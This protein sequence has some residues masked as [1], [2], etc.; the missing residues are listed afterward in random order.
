MDY[1]P[2]KAKIYSNIVPF[3]IAL[4]V[5]YSSK[6]NI[7]V[8][9]ILCDKVLINLFFKFYILRYLRFFEVYISSV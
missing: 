5:S 2:A 4:T 9:G 7:S 3:D 8:M 1:H 6:C